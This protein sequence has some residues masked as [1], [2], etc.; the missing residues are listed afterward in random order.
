[1]QGSQCF[2]LEKGERVEEVKKGGIKQKLYRYKAFIFIQWGQPK[3][4]YIYIKCVC[5]GIQGEECEIF[6]LRRGDLGKIY[7]CK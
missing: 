6:Y 5:R 2:Y 3:K 7:H 4:I 1:M